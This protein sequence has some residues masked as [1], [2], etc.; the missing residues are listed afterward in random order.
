VESRSR[1]ALELA[2]EVED[3]PDFERAL[4]QLANSLAARLGCERVAIGIERRG[5]IRLRALSNAAWFERKAD[6]SAAL[7]NA[8]EEA[9][10]QA[11]TVVYPLQF[12]SAWDAEGPAPVAVAHRDIAPR[13]GGACTAVIAVRGRSVSARSRP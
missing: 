1:L 11:R 12:R 5:R 10:D 13:E 9:C 4:M 7:E 3:E 6:F 8:M 2:A